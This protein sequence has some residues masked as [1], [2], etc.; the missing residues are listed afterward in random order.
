MTSESLPDYEIVIEDIIR[1]V[2][3]VIVSPSVIYVHAEVFKHTNA[4]YPYT[5]TEVKMMTIPSGQLNFTWDNM[6]QGL[7]TNKVVI[8]F[9][10]SQAVSGSYSKNPFNFE[11]SI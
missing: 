7:Q 3:K 4:K 2:E 10:D 11:I 6:F 5:K 9:V 8:T 1:K